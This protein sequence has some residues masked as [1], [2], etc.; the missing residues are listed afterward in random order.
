MKQK[1]SYSKISTY[2]ECPFRYKKQYIEKIKEKPKW[3]IFFGITA[4]DILEKVYK[5][6]SFHN[7]LLEDSKLKEL[8]NYYWI[9]NQYKKE[10]SEINQ[11]SYLFLNYK[12]KKEEETQKENLFKY[13][14]FYFQNNKI[15]RKFGI[16]VPFEVEF[17]DFLLTG[18]IDKLELINNKIYIIDNKVTS[19]FLNDLFESIQLGIYIF[20]IENLIKR[21][22]VEKIGYYYIKQ[23][24]E[25]LIDRTDF[26][27]YSVHQK[28]RQ[29]V[30][31]IRD[32]IFPACSNQFCNWCQFKKECGL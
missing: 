24:K 18:K 17:D 15:E 4:A 26:N 13:L 11:E 27:D 10:Y 29:A 22:S 19:N 8:I 6:E 32:N 20:A 12:S 30:S 16:E 31:G 28:L 25:Q 5:E 3:Q 21:F 7:S 2:L 23:S 9:P 1:Y 14:K